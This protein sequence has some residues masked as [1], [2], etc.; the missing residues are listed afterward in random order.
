MSD[1]I[2]EL[3]A[4]A[5]F[6]RNF[7]MPTLNDLY[8]YP[9]GNPDLKPESGYSEEI[10]LKHLLKWKKTQFNYTVSVFSNNVENW[11]VW[12]PSSYYWSPQNI[13]SVWSRGT[14]ASLGF[15]YFKGKLLLDFS[16][17]FSYVKATAL[18]S[19]NESAIG[20]QLIYTPQVNTGINLGF[21][22]GLFLFNYNMEYV[23]ERYTSPD[24]SDKIKPYILGNIQISKEFRIKN[25]AFSTFVHINNLWNYTYQTI[26]WQAMPGINIKT[27]LKI[28]FK[29]KP[30]KPKTNEKN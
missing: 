20:K 8:W 1:Y 11:I 12:L 3:F 6:S 22:Y 25:F 28:N 18:E 19:N 13:L 2:K 21:G 29:Y 9:G 30:I 14:E 26:A 24:N 7:R 16:G 27:G 5:N 4:F 23:S 17:K 15:N 10:G